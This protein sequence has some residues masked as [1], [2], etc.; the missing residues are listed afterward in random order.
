M[1]LSGKRAP[2]KSHGFKPHFPRWARAAVWSNPNF[3]RQASARLKMKQPCPCDRPWVRW[4]MAEIGPEKM[5]NSMG[6]GQKSWYL[7]M[8]PQIGLNP[9]ILGSRNA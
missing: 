9:L 3:G 4:P 7:P 8:E 5:W 1:G 2:Q 6:V